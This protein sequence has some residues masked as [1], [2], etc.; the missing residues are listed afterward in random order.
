MPKM[1]SFRN[2]AR[3]IAFAAW[4]LACPIVAGA[5]KNGAAERCQ[6]N[7]LRAAGAEARAR[8][9]CEAENLESGG[10]A[11]CAHDAEQRRAAAFLRFEE[12]G[13]CRTSDD[14]DDVGEAIDELIAIALAE[15]RPGGPA[16]SACTDAQLD[17]L[18]RASRKLTAAYAYDVRNPDPEGLAS[19]LESFQASFDRAFERAALHGDCL[20]GKSAYVGWAIVTHGTDGLRGLLNAQ[21]PCWTTELL[22]A[23]FPPGFFDEN[24]RGGAVCQT[25]DVTGVSS[26]STCFLPEPRGPGY[27]LPRSTASVLG[28]DYCLAF[29]DNDPGGSGSCGLPTLTSVTQQEADRCVEE[30]LASR[31]FD[32]CP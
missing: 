23:T 20:S 18:A 16:A 30:L 13:G 7:K 3:S 15:L 32:E 10:S 8:L 26:A 12:R 31:L 5:A 22:E 27:H 14:S 29:V 21:C 2:R 24:G 4:I 28:S 9:A 6:A 1:Q 25:G 17:T 11:P 19:R